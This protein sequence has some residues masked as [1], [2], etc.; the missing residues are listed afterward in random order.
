VHLRNEATGSLRDT[1]TNSDGYFTFASLAV[2][3]FAYEMTVEAQGF[4]NY[5]ATGITLGGG[6]KRKINLTLKVGPTTETVEVIGSTE[7]LATVDS[8]ESLPPWGIR[9][10]RTTFRSEA[11][12]PSTSKSC[13]A[14]PSITVPYE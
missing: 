3:D 2:G 10:C 8:G 14:L 11:M 5:K 6:E 7:Q 13:L 4:V 9:N 1:V 12:L